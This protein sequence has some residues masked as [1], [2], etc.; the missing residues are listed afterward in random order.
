MKQSF[1]GTNIFDSEK[2]SCAII[3]R[4]RKDGVATHGN[5]KRTLSSLEHMGHRTGE[6][7]LEGDGAGIQ[8]DIPRHIWMDRLQTKG[9]NSR[10][11]FQPD[12]TVAHFMIR[13]SHKYNIEDTIKAIKKIVS[14]YGFNTIYSDLLP[15]RKEALGEKASKS[16]MI[17]WAFAMVPIGRF[18]VTY[19]DY[20]LAHLAI[21]S[22]LPQVHVVSFSCNSVIY[23]VR[24]DV[25]T[26]INFYLDLKNPKY[27]SAIS[28]AH[29]RYSTNTN[30][31]PERAQMFSTLGH[32]GEINTIIRLRN[33]SKMIGI[34]PADKGSDSQDLDRLIEGLMFFYNLSLMEAMEIVFPPIW[35]EIQ[36]YPKDKREVYTFYKRMFGMIAQGPAAIIARQ[37]DEIVFSVDAFGLR[38]LWYGETD[39][40]FFA[41]SEKGVIDLEMMHSDPIPLAPGEKRGFLLRRPITQMDGANTLILNGETQVFDYPSMQEQVIKEFINRKHVVLDTIKIKNATEIKYITTPLQSF[42]LKLMRYYG[43]YREDIEF[44]NSISTNGKDLIGSTGY[45]GALAALREGIVNIPEYFKEIV[46]VVTNPSIDRE[47]ENLHFSL[48]TFLGARPGL[49][50]DEKFQQLE[51]EHPLL[52]SIDIQDLP[53]LKSKVN[54]NAKLPEIFKISLEG[55]KA[56]INQNINSII[57]VVAGITENNDSSIII[58]TDLFKSNETNYVDPFI[59]IGKVHQYLVNNRDKNS[60]NLRRKTSLILQSG[61]VRNV[62]D[63]CIALGLGCD[64]IVPFMIWN[65]LADKYKVKKEFEIAVKNTVNVLKV[66]IEKVISTMGIHNISGYGAL[67]ASIGLSKKIAKDIGIT[68]VLSEAPALNYEKLNNI[69]KLRKDALFIKSSKL[70]AD[71]RLYIKI[72]KALGNLAKKEN[73]YKTFEDRYNKLISKQPY[74]LKHI[75]KFKDGK[76]RSDNCDITSDNFSAPFYISAMSFGSQGEISYKAFAESAYKSNI[77][78]MNGEGGE[79]PELLGKYYHNRGQQ[80]A[81]G[82]FGVNSKLLNSTK[83]I[84][85]KIGQGAKPGE[86]GLLPGFKVTK[87]IADSRHTMPGIDLI[88]PSNNHDIY[89]IEDLA[90]LIE[91]LKIINT[92]AKISVKIPAI[93]NIGAIV[94]GIAKAQ[95]DI[96][97]ISGCDGGTGAA[98]VHALRYVGFPVELAMFE[99]HESLLHSELRNEVQLWADGGVKST[100]DILKL[101]ALGADRVGFGTLAMVAVGCTICRDCHTGTCHVGITAHYPNKDLAFA[102]GVK[103]YE[104]R[105]LSESVERLVNLFEQ[106]K[107]SLKEK[108]QQLGLKTLNELIGK[109]HF[110]MQSD[111]KESINISVLFSESDINYL[112]KKHRDKK[113]I[114]NRPKTSLERI[115]SKKIKTQIDKNITLIDY[116]DDLVGNMDRALG[117]ATSGELAKLELS[118]NKYT[119]KVEYNFGGTNV[120]G[121]GLAA[122]MSSNLTIRVKGGGQDGLAKS[123]S[124]GKLVILKGYNHDGLLVDGSVGKCFAYGAQAGKFFVQGNADSRACIRLSGADVVFGARIKQRVNDKLSN[125]AISAN[126]KGFAFEYMTGGKVVILGDPGPWICSGMTGGKIYFYIDRDMGFSI[127]SLKLRLSDAAKIDFSKVSREDIFN[128]KELLKEYADELNK[129][130]QQDQIVE[131]DNILKLLSEIKHS[132][133]TAQYS[134]NNETK[135]SSLNALKKVFA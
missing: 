119:G 88:S 61:Q 29:G 105:I 69:Y 10:I 102:N 115:I 58:F 73:D 134:G 16:K 124:G 40:E 83:Y 87:K 123:A 125:L 114:I 45:D 109:R 38:P 93:P 33:E 63:I 44:I 90:Q 30:S 7:K 76:K 67:F 100:D 51:L 57:D 135:H 98:R 11:V 111:K 9:L 37:G 52:L 35:S 28:L 66:G 89:S 46:A 74:T 19:K 20:H 113:A 49:K 85:I 17:V 5:L 31:K 15:V 41:S 84:E 39:K 65:Y 6:V 78:C 25:K 80:V 92:D 36:G 55:K 108:G 13:Q 79:L 53:E 118:G 4:V 133:V 107:G 22:E 68:S 104:P 8:T 106:M 129:T 62:H 72:W 23:K 103:E 82:R 127:D 94:S 50:S 77:L 96:I 130:G 47:R 75:I 95:A 3:A 97:C 128:I 101:M 1:Y 131:A 59:T 27:K 91:E 2:D 18:S 32:N 60:K 120:P 21:E 14:K 64:A 42:D 43:W 71:N 81:S 112:Q 122:F 48:K 132:F 70:S 56:D 12:F 24:G 99:A 26:L 121:N 86:G 116:E 110:L 34:L 117:T 54:N 126:L